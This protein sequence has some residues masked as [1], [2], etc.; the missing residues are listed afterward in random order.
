LREWFDKFEGSAPLKNT[1]KPSA[2][3]AIAAIMAGH[4]GA[5]LV[6]SEDSNPG[7]YFKGPIVMTASGDLMP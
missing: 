5:E 7:L 3:A 1:A 6:P 4:A 2:G